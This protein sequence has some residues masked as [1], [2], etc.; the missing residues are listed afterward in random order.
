[1][2]LE[3]ARGGQKIQYLFCWSLEKDG[4]K[5]QKHLKKQKK[6]YSRE[7]VESL[8]KKIFM[9]NRNPTVFFFPLPYLTYL[10]RKFFFYFGS[11]TVIRAWTSEPTVSQ[12]K[13][14][15]PLAAK[16]LYLSSG[17]K[18][19]CAPHADSAYLHSLSFPLL[20]FNGPDSISRKSYSSSSSLLHILLLLCLVIFQIHHRWANGSV[21]HHGRQEDR[22]GRNQVLGWKPSR[23]NPESCIFEGAYNLRRNIWRHLTSSIDL[24]IRCVWVLKLDRY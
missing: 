15:F 22:R 5:N 16:G 7:Y 14:F 17:Y 10:P 23:Q 18:I 6:P 19:P 8:G 9:S 24:C 4:K 20:L 21:N 3:E 11:T 12:Q 13:H 2:T 1:M